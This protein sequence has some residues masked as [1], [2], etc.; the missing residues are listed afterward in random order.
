MQGAGYRPNQNVSVIGAAGNGASVT[1]AVVR[2][3]ADGVIATTFV[4]PALTGGLT[5]VTTTNA[6]SP[7]AAPARSPFTTTTTP[8]G[9]TA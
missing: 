2:A 3:N 4:V 5:G 9:T 8:R 6:A 1:L 7:V